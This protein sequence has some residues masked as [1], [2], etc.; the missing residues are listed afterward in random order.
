M[1]TER[2]A[3]QRVRSPVDFDDDPPTQLGRDP[4]ESLRNFACKTYP[5]FSEYSP[6]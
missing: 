3:A 2:A 1:L 6:R 4:P 5:L